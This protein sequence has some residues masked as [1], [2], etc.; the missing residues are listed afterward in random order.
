[1]TDKIS[2]DGSGLPKALIAALMDQAQRSGVRRLALVGGVVRDVMLHHVHRDPWR[3]PPDLDFVL[4]GSCVDFVQR[5]REQFGDGRVPE[6]HL[7]P[8]FGTAELLVDGVLLDVA[9]ART[10]IYPAPGENPVVQLGSIEQDLARR[11]F[12]VNAMALLL[13]ADGSHLL[14]DPHSGRQHLAKRQL[15]FLH[16]NSVA[17]DPTRIL[18]G[19]RYGARLGFHLAPDALVQIQSTLAQW[20]WAWRPGDSLEAVPPALGTRLRMELELLLDREPWDQALQLLHQW[21]AL[22]V[23][24]AGLQ[25]DSRLHRRLV[26][27]RRLCLPALVVLVA[28]AADPVSLG[29]RLQIPRQQ[30]VWLGELVKCRRWLDLEV[31]R[32][33]W[34]GWDAL[35][36]TQRLEQQ[37]WSPEAVAL[38]VL[39]NTSFRRPLLRWWGRW[40]HVTSPVSARELIAQGMRP[41]PEL[42]EA[43]R[44]RR[45]RVLRQ[46]G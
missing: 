9:C 3:D 23:L 38:A 42:G 15:A 45:D 14:C 28:A 22:S 13:Q 30:Q 6:L 21:S 44:R 32:D 12:T 36:W 29:S 33:A 27:G 7:H 37:R 46:M 25:Q 11:D 43:L 26:Q 10:E 19:A 31:N 16:A 18:R 5:L 35:E 34:S 41:G 24:D 1:M 8:Q 4:E 17:D 39:D 40:R 20:P 2:I